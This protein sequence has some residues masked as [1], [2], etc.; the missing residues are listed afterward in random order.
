MSTW[1]GGIQFFF[2]FSVGCGGETI[3]FYVGWRG[4]GLLKINTVGRGDPMTENSVDGEGGI[5][6][7]FPLA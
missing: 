3:F 2:L 5:Y 4:V 7:D 6:L 1:E